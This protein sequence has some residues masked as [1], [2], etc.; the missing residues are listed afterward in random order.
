MADAQERDMTLPQFLAW[1]IRQPVLN[2]IEYFPDYELILPNGEVSTLINAGVNLSLETFLQ[3]AFSYMPHR[4]RV[5]PLYGDEQPED[6]DDEAW[7]AY[8]ERF[9]GVML[10]SG[11]EGRGCLR[12]VVKTDGLPPNNVFIFNLTELDDLDR[13]HHLRRIGVTPDSPPL[14]L[15]I[16]AEEAK[17]MLRRGGLRVCHYTSMLNSVS[18]NPTSTSIYETRK[19]RKSPLLR[20]NYY[21]QVDYPLHGFPQASIWFEDLRRGIWRVPPV[22]IFEEEHSRE[23]SIHRFAMRRSRRSRKRSN[24]RNRRRMSGRSR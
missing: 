24:R 11:I 19:V 2:Y 13:Y 10:M 22:G 6:S 1:H 5:R 15:E 8:R 18:I 7:E 12:P 20:M 4:C 21:I 14:S 16:D 3:I 23:K 17:D 9:Y